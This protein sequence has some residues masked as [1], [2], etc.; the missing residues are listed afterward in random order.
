MSEPVDAE[1]EAMLAEALGPQADSDAH[2]EAGSDLAQR[3][4]DATAGRVA[5]RRRPVLGRLG[6]RRLWA[7]AAMAA[8]LMLGAG[9][10]WQVS[11]PQSQSQPAVGPTVAVPG[12]TSV[13]AV[14]SEQAWP[15]RLDRTLAVITTDRGDGDGI[16]AE[17]A[18]L[19]YA[20]DQLDQV[21]GDTTLADAAA[22]LDELLRQWE[23]HADMEQVGLF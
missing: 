10:L 22:A 4:I 19:D 13:A 1:L 7:A 2:A 15:D 20:V 21:A 9:L 12:D 18:L 16:D 5:A 3:I 6:G 8:V 17:L 11:G 14:T 23:H